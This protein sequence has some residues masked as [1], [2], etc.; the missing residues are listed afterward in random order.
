MRAF[1]TL[2]LLFAAASA[3]VMRP[4]DT[5]EVCSFSRKWDL[6]Q[7]IIAHMETYWHP[8]GCTS[9]LALLGIGCAGKG[10]I[11]ISGCA[12]GLAAFASNVSNG[13]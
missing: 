1:A 6:P 8:Q 3:A 10:L 12:A 13:T 11:G 5:R 2:P 7:G 9:R 4:L